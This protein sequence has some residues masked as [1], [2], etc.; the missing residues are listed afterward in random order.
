MTLTELIAEVDKSD[1]YTACEG[2]IERDGE[3]VKGVYL[4]DT[5]LNTS[6]HISF[7]ALNKADWGTLVD[8]VA[9]GR[10]VDHITRVTGYFSR[11]SGWNKGK[12]AELKDRA[13]VK[14]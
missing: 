10:D 4:S 12:T 3:F 14:I 8:A 11:T 13:K 9:L 7:A 2:S 5:E 1:R 6:I